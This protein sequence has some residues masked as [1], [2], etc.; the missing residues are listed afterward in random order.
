MHFCCSLGDIHSGCVVYDFTWGR[1]CCFVPGLFVGMLNMPAFRTL[2][3]GNANHCSNS[4]EGECV[5]ACVC[6]CVCLL[7]SQHA[8]GCTVQI[9]VQI[10]FC[11]KKTSCAPNEGH[12]GFCPKFLLSFFFSLLT[13]LVQLH[14]SLPH[15]TCLLFCQCVSERLQARGLFHTAQRQTPVRFFLGDRTWGWSL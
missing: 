5:R 15:S 11:L 12:M 7:L 8:L 2:W 1:A 10:C 4:P 13:A 3:N 6:I 14:I 9:R